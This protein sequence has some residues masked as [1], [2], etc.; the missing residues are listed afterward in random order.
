M[1]NSM[2]SIDS[3]ARQILESKPVYYYTFTAIF[4]YRPEDS[5]VRLKFKVYL[6]DDEYLALLE[7]RLANRN[8]SF[9]MLSESSP[10]LYAR[11][12]RR[13]LHTLGANIGPFRSPFLILTDELD[14]DVAKATPP[15]AVSP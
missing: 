8:D 12:T 14:E 5:L 7:W 13:F 4:H 1:F 9:N 15:E 10:E 2:D 6:S 3:I 11:L